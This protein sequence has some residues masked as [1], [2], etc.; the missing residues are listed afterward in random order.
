MVRMLGRLEPVCLGE[1]VEERM[2]SL[3]EKLE[4]EAIYTNHLE[5]QAVLVTVTS[6]TTGAPCA[7]CAP[8]PAGFCWLQL[9]LKRNVPCRPFGVD[10][11]ASA[12]FAAN[13]AAT[14]ITRITAHGLFHTG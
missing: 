6:T 8:C 14:A 7:P 9:R 5:A 4:R 11:H 2:A 3:E 10:V 12:P 1:T 13:T